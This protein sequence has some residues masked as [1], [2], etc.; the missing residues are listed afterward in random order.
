MKGLDEVERRELLAACETYCTD[1]SAEDATDEELDAHDRLLSRGLIVLVDREPLPG[2]PDWV[3]D[4]LIIDA[5]AL[6]RDV[7]R[8]DAMARGETP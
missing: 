3:H 1:E 7:V 5:T 4:Y 2:E 6:G 8:W